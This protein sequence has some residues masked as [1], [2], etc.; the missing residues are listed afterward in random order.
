MSLAGVQESQ[1]V[2]LGFAAL[3][4]LVI[5]ILSVKRYGIKSLIWWI[6]IGIMAYLFISSAILD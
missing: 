3:I 5:V 1:A 6:I 4:I 2:I